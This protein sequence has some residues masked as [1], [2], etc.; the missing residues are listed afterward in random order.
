MS[1]TGDRVVLEDTLL[2]DCGHV[3]NLRHQEIIEAFKRTF[4]YSMD[5][6]ERRVD[7]AIERGFR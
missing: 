4:G 5:E 7:A 2:A 3:R 1:K 6:A